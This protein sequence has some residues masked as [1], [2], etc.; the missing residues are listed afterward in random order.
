MGEIEGTARIAS[1]AALGDWKSVLREATA[2][3]AWQSATGGLAAVRVPVITLP[4]A[5]RAQAEMGDYATAER[6]I[7]ATPLDCTLCLRV[8]GRVAA[9]GGRSGEADRWYR[10]AVSSA[11]NL[12]QSYQDWAESR[13]LMG[14]VAGAVAMA[15]AANERGPQWAEPLKTMG[16]AMVRQRDLNGAEASYAK[17]AT[18]APRWGKLHMQWAGALWRLGR[19]KEAR[20]KLDI[21][22]GMDLNLAD[23]R[24]LRGMRLK[25]GPHT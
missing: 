8:R 4:W 19:Q 14:D 22:A 15:K 11:P 6:L 10:A 1:A 23:R 13:L 12:P 24:I 21:A 17:A 25:A 3:E 20:D 9:L 7:A 16:D 2:L 5:A 18:K